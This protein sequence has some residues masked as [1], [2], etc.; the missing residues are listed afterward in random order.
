MF[1]RFFPLGIFI[2]VGGCC[3]GRSH[4]C[5]LGRTPPAEL[6]KVQARQRFR[7]S[8][9]TLLWQ[10]ICSWRW[11]TTAQ[12]ASRKL[13]L[14][15][16]VRWSQ[17]T[18]KCIYFPRK[19][20][21]E[22]GPFRPT[23]FRYLGKTFGILVCFDGVYPYVSRDFSELDALK[24]HRVDTIVWSVGSM[25]PISVF[26]KSIAKSYNFSVIISEDSSLLTGSDSAGILSNTGV[27]YKTQKD[28]P[29]TPPSDYTGKGL[30]IRLASYWLAQ[31]FI[32]VFVKS[33]TLENIFFKMQHTY[34]DIYL[35]LSPG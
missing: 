22:P 32:L 26:G 30:H 8:N 9:T 14:A 20:W 21:A 24:A 31:H 10:Q 13:Y 3:D 11:R 1:V 19:K 28:F 23:S 5:R 17:R 29:L 16:Q 34:V 4:R 15:P 35:L 27:P 33:A 12:T 2:V 6:E 25:I 18:R 7:P